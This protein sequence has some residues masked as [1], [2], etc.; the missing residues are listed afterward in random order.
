V[1][2]CMYV[3]MYACVCVFSRLIVFNMFVAVIIE[4]FQVAICVCREEE[5]V[6]VCMYVCLYVCVCVCFLAFDRLQH[7]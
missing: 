1:C 6:C 5:R 3:C 4:N 2:V 7:V